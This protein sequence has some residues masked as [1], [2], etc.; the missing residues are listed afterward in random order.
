MPLP[1]DLGGGAGVLA[2]DSFFFSPE[3]FFVSD[4]A[5]AAVDAVSAAGLGSVAVVPS[6]FSLPLFE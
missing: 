6:D 5:G 2:L 3:S 4:A 1:S